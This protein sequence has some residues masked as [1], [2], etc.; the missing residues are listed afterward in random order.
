MSKTA[1][2]A[3]VYGL[4]VAAV[5]LGWEMVKAPVADR[6]PPTV[7]VRLAPHSPGVLRRAAEGELAAG[8]VANASALASASLARAPFSARTLR[9]VGLTAARSGDV[10][11]ADSILTLAGNWS[12]RDDPAHA[13]LIERRLRQGNYASAFAHADTLARRRVDG[14]D[15]IYNLFTTAV[16]VDQRALP[17]LAAAVAR[18]PSWRSA[19]V[20]YLI[21]RDDAD[22]VIF[23]LGLTLARRASGYF[24]DELSWIYQSWYAERRF[25]AIRL[26]QSQLGRPANVDDVQN[27]DFGDP[28]ESALVP[29]GWRLD[30]APGISTAMIEDDVRPNEVALRVEYDGY[31]SG[32]VAEQILMAAPGAHVLEGQERL[33]ASS[34]SSR[35]RWTIQC[36]EN[37][38]SL[39]RQPVSVAAQSPDRWTAFQMS[40]VVPASGCGVQRLKLETDPGDRRATTIAWFDKLSI[41]DTSKQEAME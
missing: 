8:R 21:Q 6:A 36:V 1:A 40:F 19:F 16:L 30:P 26:L 39:A 38:E 9:V 18:N 28:S 7:A 34:S 4:T 22:P 27:G 35:L 23:A 14:N 3:A 29:F 25:D 2:S 12:L 41:S 17:H 11:R 37:G 24:D 10:D 15:P 20:A 32:V 31:A 33:E 5:W 13:W